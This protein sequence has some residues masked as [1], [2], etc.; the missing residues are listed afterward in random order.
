MSRNFYSEINLHVVFHTKNSMPSIT[1]E[2]EPLAWRSIH[3]KLINTPGAFVHGIGGIETHVHVC[4]SI[5][6]SICTS[7]LI[8]QMK[9]VSS[10]DVN[11]RLGRGRKL[12]Q[13][14]E[15]YGVVSFGTKDL[16]WVKAYVRNQKEHHGNRTTHERLER[17]S[18][19]LEARA[20]HRE[21]P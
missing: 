12:L 6:P 15:C 2:V 8:G 19:D 4:F 17:S 18:P 20:E 5:V 13:W 1:A 10:H 3:Q 16:E 21:S 7:E 9:G 14:Q 11:Q